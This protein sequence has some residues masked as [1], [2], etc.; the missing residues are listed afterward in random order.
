[1][2]SSTA[3]TTNLTAEEDKTDRDHNRGRGRGRG[4]D[5]SRGLPITCIR[6]F[7]FLNKLFFNFVLGIFF[8]SLGKT[9][10]RRSGWLSV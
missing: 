5:Q 1:M 9:I 7:Y 2:L 10:K 6:T 3:T 4:P 8:V